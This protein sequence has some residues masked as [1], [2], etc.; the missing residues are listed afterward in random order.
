MK[1]RKSIRD[2]DESCPGLLQYFS[3]SHNSISAE[4]FTRSSLLILRSLLRD[5]RLVLNFDGT[6]GLVNFPCC[7]HFHQKILHFFLSVNPKFSLLHKDVSLERMSGQILS[8]L[9]IAERIS[10]VNNGD[11][12][13]GF[14]QRV[15]DSL[16]EMLGDAQDV[17]LPN[18][19]LGLTD[20]S[21]AV[22][23]A[24]LMT[25]PGSERTKDHGRQSYANTVSIH[26]R[27]FDMIIF[28]HLSAANQRTDGIIEA[29]YFNEDIKKTASTIITSMRRNCG[30]FLKQCR[31]HVFRA[32]SGWPKHTLKVGLKGVP[33]A[34][35][36][37]R[38]MQ[39]LAANFT[40]LTAENSYT[41]ALAKMSLL[42]ALFQTEFFVCPQTFDRLS[43][44]QDHR[45]PTEIAI[46]ESLHQSTTKFIE[47]L[48]SSIQISSLAEVESK[49][50]P[51]EKIS[52]KYD[53]LWQTLV[54]QAQSHLEKSCCC[55]LL[56]SSEQT[57]GTSVSVSDQQPGDAVSSQGIL[58]LSVV[59]STKHTL[60]ANRSAAYSD[61]GSTGAAANDSRF[62]TPEIDENADDESKK[63]DCDSSVYDANEESPG[64]KMT[65]ADDDR[66]PLNGKHAG[67]LASGTKQPTTMLKQG[68]LKVSVRLPIKK[69]SR[70]PNPL[71]SPVVAKYLTGTWV[72]QLPMWCNA[73]IFL[74]EQGMDM[75]LQGSNQGS[76]GYFANAKNNTSIKDNSGSL[77]EYLKY[78]GNEMRMEAT[79]FSNETKTLDQS[80]STMWQRKKN[81]NEQ[82]QTV[83]AMT[84]EILVEE[85]A[86]K[87]TDPV[88]VT[89]VQSNKNGEEE[90]SDEDEMHKEMTAIQRNEKWS[91]KKRPLTSDNL[92]AQLRSLHTT[93][94]GGKPTIRALHD[95][96]ILT[97][98]HRKVLSY[99]VFASFLGSAE[100]KLSEAH[101]DLLTTYLSE[102]QAFTE[103]STDDIG[104]DIGT[105]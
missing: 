104:N 96:I 63:V 53:P 70:I 72:N 97:M 77:P 48:A 99:P 21:A 105:S 23:A 68:G 39:I 64:P 84:D 31:S 26:C 85:A 98:S 73:I 12:L 69:G 92:R 66:A 101:R 1:R 49:V 91:S 9:L 54:R 50:F 38:V 44:C 82:Q 7:Q 11:S 94:T 86:V 90:H 100:K 62:K 5:G 43:A 28:R 67:G 10:N 46:E 2:G 6:G 29:D 17:N 56:D 3:M 102:V 22:Q 42:I 27:Y 61:N 103:K 59:Y 45:S 15:K 35:T 30:M 4:L 78:R 60:I 55:Y 20:C 41:I 71:H 88:G 32:A 47:Q 81:R 95:C 36:K 40:M 79:R 14:L 75:S 83:T 18:P 58:C 34:E 24:F 80:I 51:A 52:S 25:F 89:V 93:I 13:H 16:Y 19:L 76:E 33:D 37:N 87:V 57:V 8:P 65:A 74:L